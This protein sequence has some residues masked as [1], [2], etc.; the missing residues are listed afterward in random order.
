MAEDFDIG[1][2]TW[3]KDEIDQAL[4][5]VLDNLAT[6]AANPEDVANLKFSQTHLYQ[7]SGALDM[8]GLEGC[9]RFCAEIETL[10]SKLEKKTVPYSP[11]AIVALE[12]AIKTLSAY[13]KDLL[14]GG[15]DQSLKLYP[16][17]QALTA[18]QDEPAG[19]NELFFPD[20]SIR[21]PKDLPSEQIAEEA[22]PK[23]LA[24]QRRLLQKSLLSWLRSQSNDAL[25]NLRTALEN[26][27]LVQ[28]QAVRKTFWWVATAFPDV[29]SQP[30]FSDNRHVKRLCRRIDQQLRSLADGSNRASGN[31]LRDL[32]YF[33]AVAGERTERI[34]KVRDVFELE[35]LL[36]DAGASVVSLIEIGE[37][38]MAQVATLR[39]SFDTLKDL[40]GKLSETKNTKVLDEFSNLVTEIFSSSQE[41]THGAVI[42]MI[43][44]L[45]EIVTVIGHDGSRLSDI[46]LME[47]ASGLT[48]LE[49][50]L[51][52]YAQL[53]A[54]ATQNL[55]AHA[56][57]LQD[58]A[59]GVETQQSSQTTKLASDVLAAVTK[60]IKDALEITEQALD[61][62]FRNPADASVLSTVDKPILDVVAAFDMLDLPVPTATAKASLKLI[63]H[64]RESAKA[65]D[66]GLFELV[67]ES[68]SMLGFYVEEMPRVRPESKAVLEANLLRLDEQ[69]ALIGL[70]L[71]ALPVSQEAL[72]VA[73]V[74]DTVDDVASEQFVE[75]P[76]EAVE[77]EKA[78][79]ID[80][81]FDADF[82]DIFLTEA[83]EVLANIAQN[84]QALRVN[85]T[86]KDALVEVRRG[87]HTLKGSG[88]TVGLNA[89]GEVGWAV[90]QLLNLVM[91][92]DAAPTAEQ[93]AFIEKTTAAF[94]EW[95]AKLREHAE[96]EVDSLPWQQEAESLKSEAKAS[97]PAKVSEEVVIGG[98]YK[99]SRGL[100]NIFM[101][102]A[103]EHMAALLAGV[104]DISL[105]RQSK[106][107]DDTRRAAHTLAS[108]AGT[109]G[110]TAISVLSREL[111]FWLDEHQ[112]YWTPKTRTLYESVV[113]ALNNMLLKA[114]QLRQPK[115]ILSLISA[116]REA[117]AQAGEI[118][119]IATDL[120]QVTEAEAVEGTV[121]VEVIETEAEALPSEGFSVE[122]IVLEAPAVEAEIEEAR[123]LADVEEVNLESLPDS[124]LS[125]PDSA[126]PVHSDLVNS[127]LVSP[128][129]EVIEADGPEEE[130]VV[131]E[132]LMIDEIVETTLK[133][134]QP[135]IIAQAA[136][137]ASIQDE[138]FTMFVEEARELV[139]IVG[140]E[141]RA[142][143]AVPV[144][145][146]HPDEIQRA[147]HTLKGSARMAGQSAL[148]DTVHGMEDH[149]M[150]GLKSKDIDFDTLFVDLDQIGSL[151]ED[152]VNKASGIDQVEEPDNSV[153]TDKA[154]E[155]A[156]V[157]VAKA[158]PT[159]VPERATQYLRLREDTL[160]RLIN[161]AGEISIARSRMEREVLS[162]KQFSSDLTESVHRLRNQLREMEIEAESQLQSRLAYLQEV[163]ETFDPLEFDRFTRLQEL[164]RMMAESVND[165]STIQ[166]GLLQNMD[167]TEA[168]LQQQNRMNRELQHGLMDVRMVPFSLISERLQRIVRQ[169]SRELEKQV[170]L[171]IEGESVAIDRS[172][173]EK[174]GAPL[175]HLLRN[176]VA[177]G[178]ETPAQRKKA[179]KPV[180]GT[181]VLKVLRENDEIVLTVTD[182][183]AGINLD[184][185]RTKAIENGLF[186]ADQQPNEQAL[187]SV[188]F[189]PGFSTATTITQ[190]AGRG[191]GLDSVRSDITALGGRID[192]NNAPR[193]G[194]VFSIYLP[195]TLSVS[196]VVM[197]RAGH[198]VFAIPSVM[199]EQA[200]KIKQEELAAA[201]ASGELT[202]SGRE[203]PLYFLSRL[204]GDGSHAYEEQRYTPVLLLR[205]GTYH[206]ALHVDEI[207]ES[208][209]VVMKQIG[210]QL[211]RVPG[212]VG[213]TVMGDGKIVL[214]VNPVQLANR[215][216]LA[217][218]SVH[219]STVTA[220]PVDT[221]PSILVVDDSLTMRKVLGRLLERENYK[222]TTAKDG[223]DALQVLQE[224]VPDIILTDIEMPRMDGFELVRNIKADERLV[225]IPLIII[226]SRT[227]EKHQNHAQELGVNAFL[228]KPVQDDELIAQVSSLLAQTASAA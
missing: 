162:F 110:F 72:D 47:V 152:A 205:S 90:E 84:L 146:E 14:D 141:L 113:T 215:E 11:E 117:T 131:S 144:E 195:V 127:E 120:P 132:A 193:K 196:Q 38:E 206:I 45:Y 133:V 227:A 87:Y 194:A 13:L 216:L 140:N 115:Q 111:E 148:A 121:A 157:K 63:E 129:P 122:E 95:V 174:I 85:A 70:P 79:V 93:L 130:P 186:T 49:D 8:V 161:E 98:T 22:L 108:N 103:D 73:E 179:R 226:S 171:V 54:T 164:T 180:V 204:V 39:D 168:A 10:A 177:H 220:A 114:K 214:I 203:Y 151:L 192:V 210:P 36:P 112:G 75:V 175:E 43:G 189:E 32:L 159:R 201:Y 76:I 37:E 15:A 40:W 185:V 68:L 101:T 82:L 3:V 62:F 222:V 138:L 105:E 170:E 89:L 190:I 156:A 53:S 27:Q 173:L 51:R 124:A 41:L 123:V 80:R 67:A 125:E 33:I 77:T 198:K 58:I 225:D 94:A 150:R 160:D 4:K 182:D 176:A 155:K 183:G 16:A 212:I 88:R 19:A 172:V 60:Q 158:K 28:Q 207:M 200:Q 228:G 96:V 181:I 118:T 109:T 149:V 25:D 191:V 52:D 29:L 26:V 2:L 17:L 107:S 6:V 163:S 136:L 83:E 20:T 178:M 99:I 116:L 42:E 86:D 78:T 46:L 199:I 137:D 30:E 57:L 102:E 81:A 224:M 154:D 65:P 165:V 9:K 166:L 153:S 1:P 92:R 104:A 12:T 97:K 66:Q 50:A 188:I 139:P 167:E 187:L 202:W 24:E 223:M 145:T 219:V 119:S 35:S 31:L 208:V 56:Y 18:I 135:T 128:E 184:R 69:L 44:S 213:A 169:T 74:P 134:V 5:S 106:P 7:V 64:F 142:W 221:T 197:V 23:Y 143:R 209:E 71:E 48:L 100:F 34:A 217:I 211:A 55:N 126:E 21:V 61:T 59:S 91:E 147:L 218:G